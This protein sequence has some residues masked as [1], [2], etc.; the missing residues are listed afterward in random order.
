MVERPGDA[1]HSTRL[2]YYG[3]TDGIGPSGGAWIFNVKPGCVEIS[4][5]TGGAVTHR[6]RAY[7]VAGAISQVLLFPLTTGGETAFDCVPGQP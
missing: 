7:V 6:A 4:A 5:R 2:W 3:G 1:P